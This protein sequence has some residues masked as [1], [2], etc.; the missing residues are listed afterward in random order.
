MGSKCKRVRLQGPSTD[1]NAGP[2]YKQKQATTRSIYTPIQL[3][4]RISISLARPNGNSA[5]AKRKAVTATVACVNW[6][7]NRRP[8]GPESAPISLASRPHELWPCPFN[9]LAID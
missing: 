5:S 4:A 8:L 2:H 3:A 7:T 9:L 1:E 6:K